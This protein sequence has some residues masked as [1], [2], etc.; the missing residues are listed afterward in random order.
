MITIGSIKIVY[1]GI[2]GSFDNLFRFAFVNFFP[3]PDTF[4]NRMAPMPRQESF[5]SLN[6]LYT[7]S[8][9]F[10]NIYWQNALGNNLAQPL[11]ALGYAVEMIG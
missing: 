4:G 2:I 9:S 7:I 8:N 1:T 5:K 3:W 11:I 10:M 6:F